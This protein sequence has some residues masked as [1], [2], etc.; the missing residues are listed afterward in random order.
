MTS[1]FVSRTPKNLPMYNFRFKQSF[2]R[3][4]LRFR[5]FWDNFGS[6]WCPWRHK[7]GEDF[8]PLN[9]WLHHWFPHPKKLAHLYFHI[10]T[11]NSLSNFA[12]K[13]ILGP[14]WLIL[15]VRDVTKGSIFLNFEFLTSSLVSLPQNTYPWTFLDR[16]NHFIEYFCV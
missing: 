4:F 6:F 15:G 5:W 10:E 8:K 12:F 11:I 16:N 1:S 9:F 3:V 14:F 7:R 2:Y 13:V